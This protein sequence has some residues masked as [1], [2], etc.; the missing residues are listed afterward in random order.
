MKDSLVPGGEILIVDHLHKKNISGIFKFYA[1][2]VSRLGWMSC[3]ALFCRNSLPA[4]RMA[5]HIRGETQFD[6][7]GF[8]E[9]Y[10]SFFPGAEIGIKSGIFAYLKWKKSG[11]PVPRQGMMSGQEG[12]SGDAREG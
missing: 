10:E 3:A 9:R 2:A 1:A 8:R 12:D 6:I 11:S 5:K 7:G 4:S